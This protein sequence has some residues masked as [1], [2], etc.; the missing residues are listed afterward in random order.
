MALANCDILVSKLMLLLT[1]LRLTQ[2]QFCPGHLTFGSLCTIKHIP[3]GFD[4]FCAKTPVKNDI[5]VFSHSS[6]PGNTFPPIENLLILYR[7]H[8][9]SQRLLAKTKSTS[10]VQYSSNMLYYE[11]LS[12]VI[13]QT[14]V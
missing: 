11:C 14:H 3:L 10:D 6:S 13:P 9:N 8:C 1:H 4:H 7:S 5:W 2:T 12:S